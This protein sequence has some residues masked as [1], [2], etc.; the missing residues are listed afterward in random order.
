[1]DAPAIDRLAAFGDLILRANLNVTSIDDP[2]DVERFHFLDS[3][4][5]LSVDSVKS[6]CHLADVGSGAGLPAVVLALALPAA[7]VIA[8][9]SQ[10]KKCAYTGSVARELGLENLTPVC[11]RAEDYGRAGGR[12][13]HDVV[14]TRAVAPLAVV[15]EYSLPL[16]RVGGSMVAMKGLVS[17]QE[18]IQGLR[19]LAILGAG[20]LEA[21]RLHPFEGSENRWAFVAEKVRPTPAQFPRRPGVPGKRPLGSLTE[22]DGA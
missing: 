6:A 3:L 18:R 11:A 20:G 5:L 1:L 14:V 19:A 8:V 17:D 16:L 21:V 9:E 4:S 13:A 2:D 15:A 12:G 22:S 10:R 7:Q